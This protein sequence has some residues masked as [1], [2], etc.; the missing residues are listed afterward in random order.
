MGFFDFIFGKDSMTASLEELYTYL[1]SNK[2]EYQII[3]QHP[4]FREGS[5][6]LA[7]FLSLKKRCKKC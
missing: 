1:N 6:L 7:D 2:I 4:Q 3:T 5:R